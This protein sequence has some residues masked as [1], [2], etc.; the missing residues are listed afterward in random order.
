[1]V[2]EN[3]NIPTNC[4]IDSKLELLYFESLKNKLRTAYK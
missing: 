4:I 2:D 1:M 3:G